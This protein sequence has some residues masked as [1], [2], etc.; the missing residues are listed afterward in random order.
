VARRHA[1]VAAAALLALGTVAYLGRP[2]ALHAFQA[3]PGD[4]P[5]PA[6]DGTPSPALRVYSSR[7]V[8]IVGP[9]TERFHRATGLSVELCYGDPPTLGRAILAG[10]SSAPLTCTWGPTSWA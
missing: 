1:L 3:P 5:A 9:V 2:S 7:D 4:G 10:T 8:D 6:C